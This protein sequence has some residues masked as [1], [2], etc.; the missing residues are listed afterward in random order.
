MEI[1]VRTPI[2][3]ARD[4]KHEKICNRFLQLSNENKGVKPH[5]IFDVIARE[6]CMTVPGVKN[7]IIQ[8]GL[9]QTKSRY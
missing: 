4:E 8:K 5:R 7:V 2:E 3:K 1:D 6:V 9:Y